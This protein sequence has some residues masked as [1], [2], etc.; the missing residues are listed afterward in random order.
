MKKKKTIFLILIIF[1]FLIFICLLVNR[2]FFKDYYYSK[3]KAQVYIPKYSYFAKESENSII[4]PVECSIY[5][6]ELN[7]FRSKSYLE[8]FISNYIEYLPSCYDEGYFYDA[9]YNITYSKYIVESLGI[10]K[11]LTIVFQK[12]NYCEKEYVLEDNWLDILKDSNVTDYNF[13]YEKLF[14]LLEES[15]RLKFNSRISFDENNNYQISYIYNSFGYS[16]YL[17]KHSA[18]VIGITR[19]D[20]ND[21]AKYAIYDIGKDVET[22]FNSL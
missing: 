4:Y 18:N 22:F 21:T 1:L 2:T 3:D 5:T 13:N 20:S 14:E 7:S 9:D 11:K 19:I 15:N 17:S 16:L 6:L 10:Q 8:K 12:G